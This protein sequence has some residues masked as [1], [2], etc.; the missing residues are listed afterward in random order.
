[1]TTADLE[2]RCRDLDDD[3]LRAELRF[4]HREVMTRADAVDRWHATDRRSVVWQE[5]RKRLGDDEARRVFLAEY[6]RV[7]AERRGEAP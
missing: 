4:W 7:K 2:A 1:M 6:E 3:A 5:L